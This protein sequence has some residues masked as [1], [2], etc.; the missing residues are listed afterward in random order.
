MIRWHSITFSCISLLELNSSTHAVVPVSF[1]HCRSEMCAFVPTTAR[2]LPSHVGLRRNTGALCPRP[3]TAARPGRTTP[4]AKLF[5][6]KERADPNY[7]ALDGDGVFTVDNIR[8]A[9]GSKHR[10]KRKG[11]GHAAGQGGP[12]GFGMRGQK[13]RSGRGT[14]PGFEGGQTPLYRRIP[15]FVGRP[16][17]PGHKRKLY[18]LIKIEHLNECTEGASVDMAALQSAGVTTRQKLKLVKVVGGTQLSVSGLTVRAHKFT[19]SAV[20]EITSKGGVCMQ[21][22]PT[23]GRDI[24]PL[25]LADSDTEDEA[26]DAGEVADSESESSESE[27]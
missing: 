26:V 8:P 2:A 3:T 4:T 21:I 14:R 27:N 25:V 12:C 10:K 9:P 22:S 11:R 18:S 24:A 1:L 6:W 5:A 16:M 20:N 7:S 23:T 17:G 19:R 15:K 13:S